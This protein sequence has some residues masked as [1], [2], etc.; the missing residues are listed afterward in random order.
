[1]KMC[2]MN[3][4]SRGIYSSTILDLIKILLAIEID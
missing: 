4:I 3:N 1:M 2:I